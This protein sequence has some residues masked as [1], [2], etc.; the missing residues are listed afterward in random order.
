MRRPVAGSTRAT[1]PIGGT[2]RSRGSWI[3]IASRSW[4]SPRRASGVDPLGAGEVGD[5]GDEP[6]PLAEPG[7]AVDRAGE[8]AAPEVLRHGRRGDRREDGAH[9]VGAGAR[10]HHLEVRAGDEHGADAVL[11][12]HRE[13][14][15]ARRGGERHLGLLHRGRA[16][17]HRRRDVDDQPGLEVAVGDL[18]AHV[19]LLVRAVTFQSMRRTSSPGWY[20]R[21]SPGSLPW[22]GVIPW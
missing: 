7:D 2:S 12:A 11:V 6:A 14:P 21:D 18:V 19:G 22:P 17:A 20:R 4:R 16:E 5:H 8:V 15:D 10:R 13:E 3:G 9:L 1:R